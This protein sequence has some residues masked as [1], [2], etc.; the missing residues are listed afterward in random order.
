MVATAQLNG[1]I[2]FVSDHNPIPAVLARPLVAS[3]QV[4]K[5]QFAT[6]SPTT[7]LASLND[8]TVAGQL[9][10]GM[11][12][13][14]ELTDLS[15]VSGASYAR[16]SQR[17]FFG[18]PA[19]TLSNDGFTDADWCVPFYIANENT[20][21]KLSS[22]AGVSRTLGGLVF[23]LAQGGNGAITPLL[24][25]GPIAQLI[26]RSLL[27]TQAKVGAWAHHAVDAT[28]ATTTAEKTMAR[29]PVHGV[30][31]GI[32]FESLGTIAADPTDYVTINVYKA[33]GAGGTHVLVGSYDS[34]AAAQ[35]ALAAGV[36]K[37][38][39]LS[40]VAGALNVLET[41]IFS[42]EVLKAASG[43]IVP[44][45]TLRVVQKAI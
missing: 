38:F 41:D 35:G 5:G 28:A 9:A 10:A 15:A 16:L 39:L 8:G 32:D 34:R 45:G 43:K 25:G 24:W 37:A 44:V 31:T 13:V 42:Y 18:V 29:E 6:V 19:S 23:G 4:G 14:V 26:A 11:G 2:T 27:V 20:P 1:G 21:G 7:G 40:V 33:D 3:A 22:Y 17:F 12:D 36:P 30:V